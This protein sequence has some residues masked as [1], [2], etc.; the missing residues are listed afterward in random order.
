M[1]ANGF[2]ERVRIVEVGPR[3]GLQAERGTVSI[4]TKIRLIDALSAAGLPAVEAGAFVSPKWVSQMADSAEVL[5][6]I[7]RRPGTD[8]PVLV[9][10]MKG[11]DLIDSCERL[12]PGWFVGL[13]VRVDRAIHAAV[14]TPRVTGGAVER[15][16]DGGD[17]GLVRHRVGGRGERFR[18]GSALTRVE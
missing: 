12:Q 3:D 16:E 17:A 15:R 1:P 13:K 18:Q 14:V 2:P 7:V 11:L 9:P 10:N 5:A 6:G 8:Y 4:E